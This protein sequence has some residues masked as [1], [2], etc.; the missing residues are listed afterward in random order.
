MEAA[1]RRRSAGLR[2]VPPLVAISQNLPA[3]LTSFV[4]R[5]RELAEVTEALSTTRLLT[6][7][8][9]GVVGRAASPIGRQPRSWRRFLMASGGWSSLR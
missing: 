7:T 3:E 9:A 1:A 5:A 2:P 4:G 6:L 8:G